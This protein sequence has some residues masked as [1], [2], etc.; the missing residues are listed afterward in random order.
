MFRSGMAVDGPRG[1]GFAYQQY[2][3]WDIQDL[4]YWQDESNKAVMVLDANAKILTTLRKFYSNLMA[5]KDFPDTLKTSCEDQLS[6][7]LSQLDEITAE[8]DMQIARAKLLVN[9][10]SDRKQLVLQHLQTQVSDRT[11]QLNKNLE[12]ET[13]VMRIITILTLI[14]LPATFVSTFF[15]TDIIKFQDQNQDSANYENGSFSN[16]ALERWLQVTIPLT[17]LT[18]FG[19]WSTYRFYS[20]SA[21]DLTV[22][23]RLKRTMLYAAPPSSEADSSAQMPP[24]D[25]SNTPHVTIEG[26]AK[27]LSA[28]ISR[29]ASTAQKFGK[30]RTVLPRYEG[31][32]AKAG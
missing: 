26:P 6:D 23:E 16:L 2:E 5:H 10:I 29:F 4:Q 28:S 31:S 19:A 24:N 20:I 11:E 30:D 13:V 12:R 9:I 14:Y 32:E 27:R 25:G 15:S 17:A 21:R 8:F 7:F 1:P 22:T 18:L 3:A